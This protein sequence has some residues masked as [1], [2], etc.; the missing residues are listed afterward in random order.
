MSD[1]E[2]PPLDDLLSSFALGP[3]WARGA[4]DDKKKERKPKGEPRTDDRGDGPRKF[5][6]DRRDDRRGGGRDRGDRG[7]RG[8]FRGKGGRGDDRRGAP[9]RHEDVPPEQ[10][11]RVTLVP[12]QEAVHLIGKEIHQVARV[13]PL[14][15]IAKTLLAE[16]KRCRAVFEAAEPHAPLFRGK[17]E[18][19]VFLTREEAVRHLWQSDLRKEFVEEETVEVDPPTG[20]FQVVARCGISGEWLGPPNFHAYQTN[21]HR[22]HRERFSHLPLASYMAKVRTERGEEAVNAW[23]ESM[24]QR[25]RWRV[26]GGGEDEPWVDDPSAAERALSA[27]CFDTAFEETRRAEV[28]GDISAKNLSPSLLTSLKLAGGHARKHPAMLIPAVCRAVET[29]HLPVFKRQGKLFTGP[30]RPHPL[31]PNAV[32]A[33][34]PGIMVEWIRN[35]KPAKLEGLWKALLPEGSTA[36]PSEFAADLFWLLTQGHILLFTDDTL[37]VQELREPTPASEGGGK[38]KKKKGKGTAAAPTDSTSPADAAPETPTEPAEAAATT[39]E[40]EPATANEEVP[41]PVAAEAPSDSPAAESAAPSAETPAERTAETPAER[42]AE[43]PAEPA[44]ETPAEPAVEEIPEPQ[45]APLVEQ[46]V[47]PSPEAIAEREEHQTP[48]DPPPGEEMPKNPPS[49]VDEPPAP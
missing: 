17:T 13:Y 5:R 1:P 37:V 9:P 22:L 21:L 28:N 18:D 12:D 7:D 42:T 29:E 10:G 11:V 20:N 6:D 14:F 41:T 24:K 25:T 19:S 36:P 38:K 44:A 23:L 45:Q 39:P 31:P 4:S 26:K 3:A 40:P 27:R 15:D 34:R 48:A 33:E 46:V 35:N 43:T 32:L 30:A 8:G 16:R 49:G 47:E 2:K